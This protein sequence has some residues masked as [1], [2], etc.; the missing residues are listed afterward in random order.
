VSESSLKDRCIGALVGLAAGDAIGM[1][2]EFQAR[3][4]YKP[5]TDM[6]PGGPFG[7]RAGEWTDDTSLALC[8]ADS[9]LQNGAFDPND[10]MARA[11]SWLRRGVNSHNGLCFDIGATTERAIHAFERTGVAA[12][13]ASEEMAAGNGSIMRLAPAVIRHHANRALAVDVAIR[14]GKATHAA[15]VAVACTNL[16]AEI[17]HDIVNGAPKDV[18]LLPRVFDGDRRVFDLAKGKY[19]GLERGGIFSS[20]FSLHTLGAA[21]WCIDQT[22]DFASAVLLAANLGG[23]TD[24]VAA[25]TGQFAGALY[26]ERAIPAAWRER[27]AWYFHIRQKAEQLFVLGQKDAEIVSAS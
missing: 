4:S 6:I 5:I 2:A 11:L 25:V 10:F 20:P 12:D 27:L 15:P 3:D 24:T 14:Q 8:L 7:L 9:L 22:E 21:L 17:L 19:R 23:D 1:P 26:G 13:G 18:A 16:M